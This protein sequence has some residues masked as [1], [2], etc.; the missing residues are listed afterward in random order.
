MTRGERSLVAFGSG[1]RLMAAN[2][3]RAET[4]G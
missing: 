4:R 3:T 2:R 1:A